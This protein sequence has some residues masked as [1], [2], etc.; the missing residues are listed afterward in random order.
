ME[1]T[2]QRDLPSPHLAHELTRPA[3]VAHTGG[4]E[5]PSD[6]VCSARGCRA[7]ADFGLRWN[8]PS[9]HTPER[10]KTWLACTAHRQ[11]LSDFLTL[12]GFLRETVAA[13]QLRC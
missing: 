6:L 9:L 13:E 1:T 5:P 11:H 12:R 10:R 2:P 7:H 3:A 8:N 4:H